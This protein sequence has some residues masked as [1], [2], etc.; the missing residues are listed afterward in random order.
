M[1]MFANNAAIDCDY[2]ESSKPRCGLAKKTGYLMKNY[3]EDMS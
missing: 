2:E 1:Q 3:R